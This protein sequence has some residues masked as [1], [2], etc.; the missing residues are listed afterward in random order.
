MYMPSA[1]EEA[2]TDVLSDWMRGDPFAV[3]TVNG[4]DGP[5][6]N[7][8]PLHWTPADAQAPGT[9]GVLRGHAA[10]GNAEWQALRAGVEPG[11]SVGLATAVAV[12]SGPHAYVSPS[13]YP[14]K[15]VAHKAVPTW[16]YVTVHARGRLRLVDDAA[17]LREHLAALTLAHEGGFERPW[18]LDDAPADFI[19]SMIRGVVG[20]ELTVTSLLGKCK[21]SQNRSAEDRQG[22]IDHLAQ[23][24]ALQQAM[25][26]V[27]KR[28]G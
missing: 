25:A 23:G 28:A 2:R 15:K 8:L 11:D 5:I 7:Q 19:D 4:E 16:N 21:A 17:W 20:L 26:D 1:F 9:L 18:S 22:V 24:D 27:M 3:L 13:W 14:S 12:F 10:R 6:V